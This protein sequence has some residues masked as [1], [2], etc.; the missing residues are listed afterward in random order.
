MILSINQ[1]AYLPWLGYFD[2]IEKSD[3]HVVL[4]HVQFEKNSFVNRNKIRNSSEAMWLTVPVETKGKFGQLDIKKIKINN[5]INWKKKHWKSIQQSYSK[6]TYFN[7]HESFFKELYQSNWMYLSELCKKSTDYILEN[8]GV[9]TEI[10]YSSEMDVA[11]SKSELIL[12]ICKHLN[13]EIYLSGPFG[14]DYLDKELFKKNGIEICYH[15]YMHPVYPQKNS[16]MFMSNL[17]IIDLLFNHGAK[18]LDIIQ[19]TQLSNQL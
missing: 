2:R 13:A 14:K 17:S 11:G 18:S 3:V 6:T 7:S 9:R 8:I 16:N 10:Y 12:N 19:S 5:N 4:D 15:D 1:P